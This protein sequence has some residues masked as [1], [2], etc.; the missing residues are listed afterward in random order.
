M[1]YKKCP[2]GV[3]QSGYLMKQEHDDYCT[4]VQEKLIIKNEDN[5]QASTVRGHA[6]LGINVCALS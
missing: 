6:E 4:G 1:A 2:D 5:F 3:L